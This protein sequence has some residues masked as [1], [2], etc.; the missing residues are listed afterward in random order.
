MVSSDR[1]IEVYVNTP[2]EVCEQRDSK[3]IYAQARR[4]EIEN[5]TGVDDPYE[6]PLDPEIILGTVSSTAEGNALSI[7]GHLVELGFARA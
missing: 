4:G 7:L 3:G 2:L 1:I 5:F 6:A